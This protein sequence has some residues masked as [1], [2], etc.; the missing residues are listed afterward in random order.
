MLSGRQTVTMILS[1]KKVFWALEEIS[2]QL[3]ITKCARR[4]HFGISNCTQGN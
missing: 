1:L 2:F 3:A 4:D